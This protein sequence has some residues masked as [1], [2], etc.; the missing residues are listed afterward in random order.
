MVTHIGSAVIS[1]ANS[2]DER[3]T[4]GGDRQQN[5][6]EQRVYRHHPEIIWPAPVASNRLRPARREELPH[7]HSLF[8]QF[9]AVA[10]S[11]AHATHVMR[12][13]ASARNFGAAGGRASAASK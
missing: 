9:A 1:Y 12:D 8:T 10:K 13:T 11:L 5:A 2:G 3:E 4:D 6:N 7:R